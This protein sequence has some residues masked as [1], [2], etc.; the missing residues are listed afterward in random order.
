MILI[1]TDLT[2][3]VIGIDRTVSHH[4]CIAIICT[5]KAVHAIEQTELTV[6]V[7]LSASL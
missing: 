6:N 4:L 3:Q 5:I 1:G 7:F 2:G